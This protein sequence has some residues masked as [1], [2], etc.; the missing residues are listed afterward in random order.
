MPLIDEQLL[1][2]ILD[3]VVSQRLPAVSLLYSFAGS[4]GTPLPGVEVR[5]ATETLKN[6]GR[7]YAIHAQG[8]EDN[9]QV[10]L[11]RVLCRFTLSHEKL[12]PPQPLEAPRTEACSAVIPRNSVMVF[13]V[14]LY[15]F[16]A[17]GSR[18]T[19]RT[20]QVLACREEHLGEN[21]PLRGGGRGRLWYEEMILGLLRLLM[22]QRKVMG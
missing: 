8:D 14:F 10:V 18:G 15:S 2:C 12:S 3:F 1:F 5:I 4:V 19:S 22:A 6:G 16:L 7:S 11:S 13:R 21:G 9:T 20:A 17:D